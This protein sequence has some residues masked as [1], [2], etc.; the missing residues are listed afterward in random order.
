M[1]VVGQLAQDEFRPGFDW[2]ARELE[3]PDQ[4]RERV[5][6]AV[7]ASLYEGLERRLKAICAVWPEDAQ[8]PTG[9]AYLQASLRQELEEDDEWRDGDDLPEVPDREL[10][11]LLL[12]RFSHVAQRLC[13]N[14]QVRE[15][16]ADP[17]RKKQRPFIVM[18]RTPSEEHAL[19][20]RGSNVLLDVTEGL[21]LM[22]ELTCTH[23][24]CRC[25]FDPAKG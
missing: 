6:Q 12:I 21:R 10:F 15:Y 1:N 14:A 8:W 20:G 4:H 23:P 19:C 17:S 13:R 25:T 22:E 9:H 5:F 24:A 2:V 7:H 16:Y 11:R 3:L 18:N